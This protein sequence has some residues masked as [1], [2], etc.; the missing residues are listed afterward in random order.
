[1][2][3][4]YARKHSII[5]RGHSTSITLE[6]EF[7]NSLKDIA[8]QRE[9]SINDVIAAIDA[10]NPDNLSSAIRVFVLRFYKD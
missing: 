7:W 9:Q 8:R 2:P 3:N 10:T 4:R 5:V 1:M 6:D